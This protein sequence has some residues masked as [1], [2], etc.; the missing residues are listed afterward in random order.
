[1]IIYPPEKGNKEISYTII[2]AFSKYYTEEAISTEI[3][4][5]YSKSLF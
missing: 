3:P 1:M 4:F 2:S 5:K